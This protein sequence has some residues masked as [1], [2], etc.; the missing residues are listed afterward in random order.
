MTLDKVMNR[1]GETHYLVYIQK[2]K[3]IDGP[4]PPTQIKIIR[5]MHS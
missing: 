2:G 1:P 5:R 4:I 3:S